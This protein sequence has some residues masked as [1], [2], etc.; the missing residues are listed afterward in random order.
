[1]KCI[2]LP[3]VDLILIS[4]EV[5]KNCDKLEKVVGFKNVE[6]AIQTL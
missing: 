4:D 5:K 3:F 2:V 6:N 1:M